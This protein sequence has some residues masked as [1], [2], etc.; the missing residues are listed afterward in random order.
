MKEG[1]YVFFRM[2]P[3]IDYDIDMFWN[4]NENKICRWYME[5]K[6]LMERTP[7]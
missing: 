2:I 3:D 5:K 6:K 1:F 7:K 4:K